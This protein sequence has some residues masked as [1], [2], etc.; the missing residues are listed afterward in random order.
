MNI[1]NWNANMRLAVA[2]ALAM[3]LWVVS[4]VFSQ[5]KEEKQNEKDK[6]QS[7]FTVQVQDVSASSYAKPIFVRARTEANRTV[8]VAAEIDGKVV[9]TPAKEGAF[10]SKGTPL[11]ELDEEDRPLQLEQAKANLRKAELDYQGALKLKDGGYQ[12]E[13][14]IAAAG[15]QLATAKSQVKSGQL[16]IER[17][18]VRAPFDGVVEKRM[19]DAGTFVQRGSACAQMLELTPLVVSGQ[20]SEQ[21]MLAITV[22]RNAEVTLADGRK[23]TGTVRYISH[24][25][26]LNTRTFKVEVEIANKNAL[27]AEGMSAQVV[28]FTEP[29]QAH[30]ISP[31]LLALKDDGKLGVKVVETQQQLNTVKFIGVGL[32][33]DD[34]DGVWVVGLPEKVTL[35]TVGQEYVADGQEV[36]VT[37]AVSM[38]K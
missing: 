19:V 34:P 29:Q 4:G 16:A 1:K 30:L 24:A 17:L 12:S 25:A 8:M 36:K 27:W 9:A 33:G 23:E 6:S 13:A 22:G 3:L 11:C 35:I 31:S 15:S 32:L 14:Q 21:E 20:V 5:K 7:L 2:L 10:V 26:D 18:I 38:N 37:Q 28:V